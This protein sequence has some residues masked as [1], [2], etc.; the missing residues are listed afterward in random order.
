MGRTISLGHL[1]G[2]LVP[3]F[4]SVHYNIVD[5]S[6][7]TGCLI[8]VK[9]TNENFKV[10]LNIAWTNAARRC[11]QSSMRRLSSENLDLKGIV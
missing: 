4:E 8:F 10:P 3:S 5:G 9:E 1:L 6:N 7:K 11:H 2:E